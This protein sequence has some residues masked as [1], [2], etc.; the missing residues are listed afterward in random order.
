MKM[1]DKIVLQ[2]L[3][4]FNSKKKGQILFLKKKELEIYIALG[5]NLSQEKDTAFFSFYMKYEKV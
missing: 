2:I 4:D 5:K 3:H 1:D